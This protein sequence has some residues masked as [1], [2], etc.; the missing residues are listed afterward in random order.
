MCWQTAEEFLKCLYELSTLAVH[1]E[2]LFCE[3][4]KIA[5][6]ILG[7][8]FKRVD[9]FTAGNDLSYYFRLSP[10]KKKKKFTLCSWFEATDHYTAYRLSYSISRR[11]WK[12]TNKLFFHLLDL[13]I[14]NSYILLSS[15]GANW[16]HRDFRLA[17]VEN[18]L[19]LAARGPP[20]PQRPRGRPPAGSS[21]R[22]RIG[23]VTEHHWPTYSTSRL[24]CRECSSR[25]K[26]TTIQTKCERC[27]VGLCISGC[28]RDFHTK[29]TRR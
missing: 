8:G 27:D 20:R 24:R 29:A 25:G 3:V 11:T 26:R 13:T 7:T 17:L 6:F 5:L 28:F 10:N 23:E 21:G 1:R 15:C 4:L 16:T 19:E 14:L 2:V 18:M 9:N 12:W 22:S